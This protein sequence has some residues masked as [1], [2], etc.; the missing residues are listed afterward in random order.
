MFSVVLHLSGRF[1]SEETPVPLGPR[2]PGQLLAEAEG[3][4]PIVRRTVN[5]KAFAF[6]IVDQ[7]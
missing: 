4:M 5:R 7:L 6:F 3:A 2:Q 1:L